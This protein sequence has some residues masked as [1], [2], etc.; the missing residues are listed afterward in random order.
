[1]HKLSV[2]LCT[3]A[4]TLLL[5]GSTLLTTGCA[6]EP[7]CPRGT[8]GE[9]G[10]RCQLATDLGSRP[11]IPRSPDV[12]AMPDAAAMD[13]TDALG[14]LPEDAPSPLDEGFS[15]ALDAP[16]PIDADVAADLPA[17]APPPDD[18]N[19]EPDTQPDIQPDTDGPDADLDAPAPDGGEADAQDVTPGADTTNQTGD[20]AT[21]SDGDSASAADADPDP[22]TR[23]GG[24]PKPALA[25]GRGPL[26]GP[27]PHLRSSART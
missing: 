23:P 2:A 19:T 8:V 1:M 13:A 18:T 11:E 6:A 22:A 4:A 10:L 7:K 14:D 12:A 15:E 9:G 27:Q 20:V 5:L 21:D 17:D 3:V 24:L 16:A 26:M 25:C